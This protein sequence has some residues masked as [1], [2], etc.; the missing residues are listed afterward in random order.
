[1][2]KKQETQVRQTS[3]TDECIH[4]VYTHLLIS[5]FF[6]DRHEK[7]EDREIWI[8]AGKKKLFEPQN[9]SC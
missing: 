9:N 5:Y 8:Y 4:V 3:V 6:F 2:N 1:M 7:D